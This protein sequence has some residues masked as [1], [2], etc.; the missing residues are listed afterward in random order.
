MDRNIGRFLPVNEFYHL[1]RSRPPKLGRITACSVRWGNLEKRMPGSEPCAE[2]EHRSVLEHVELVALPAL[3]L[4]IVD[5]ERPIADHAREGDA[6][7]GAELEA[8][9][10]DGLPGEVAT[11]A[12]PA[13]V[14]AQ[15]ELVSGRH[16]IPQTCADHGIEPVDGAGAGECPS[17]GQFQVA[18]TRPQP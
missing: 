1:T 2:A 5:I 6:L 16:R 18:D 7:I 14:A 17:A 3:A 13:D 4:H 15:D 10:A 8:I 11:D 9:G 12:E